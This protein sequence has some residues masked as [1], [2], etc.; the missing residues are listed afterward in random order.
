MGGWW[1]DRRVAHDSYGVLSLQQQ[2]QVQEEVGQ[3][4]KRRR[5]PP[6]T[7]GLPES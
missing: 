5:E 1:M 2:A 6:A 3:L 4:R 7:M